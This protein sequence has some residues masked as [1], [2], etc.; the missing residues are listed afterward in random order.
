[1]KDILLVTN[2]WHFECEKASSRY[3]TLANMIAESGNNL[4]VITSTFYHATKNQRKYENEFLNSFSYK[5]T[6]IHE[7]GY[8]KNVS[9]KRIISHKEFANNVLNYIKN[10][11]KPDV[12]YCVVPSLEVAYLITKYA[13]EKGIR[14]IVDI[15]DLWP[16]AYKMIINIPIISNL[17]FY[18]MASKANMIYKAADELVAVSHTYIDRAMKVN[19]KCKQGHSVFLGMELSKFDLY[20]SERII[21]NKPVNEIWIAYIGTLG[22]SY[23]LISVI[24]AL[25]ILDDRGI[26]NIKFIVMGDGP[27]RNKFENH[28]RGLNVN[29]EFIGKLDYKEM[30]S[31]LTSCDI[32]VN[33]II[34]NSAA[35]IINKHA[36][37]AAAGLPIINTQ[38]SFEFRTLLE[39]NNA[40]LNC[41]NNNPKDIADKLL[42]LCKDNILR[43]TMGRNSR[44]IAEEKFDRLKTYKEIIDL[45]NEY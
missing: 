25:K 27:L 1:M 4:E 40:G 39:K 16:E 22:H 34:K 15:Q 24:E 13:K 31:I 10:R 35:S 36:D 29:V 30:V 28:A 26:S 23:D 14:V 42:R 19:K 18:P 12:I 45:I 32:A 21:L 17:L 11:K 8:S 38:E 33:P 5:I 7:S 20:A 44:K 41:E 2:Y 43:K 3:F 37:Y 6:L 9:I